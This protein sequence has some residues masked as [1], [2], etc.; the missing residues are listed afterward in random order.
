MKK[1][2]LRNLA[3]LSAAFLFSL[4]IALWYCGYTI[5][6][7]EYPHLS[8][9]PNKSTRTFGD[10]R[11]TI[12]NAKRSNG[13]L[14]VSFAYEWVWISDPFDGVLLK[15]HSPRVFFYDSEGVELGSELCGTGMLP[16][17]SSR[18]SLLWEETVIVADH[19]NA[20]SIDLARIIHGHIN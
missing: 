10:L 16:P 19:D 5:S 17:F 3:I 1:K 7:Y 8:V 14:R 9:I 4:S 11:V 15:H 20:T 18:S 13:K 12:K 6:F 2:H